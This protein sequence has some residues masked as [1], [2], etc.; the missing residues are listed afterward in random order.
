[1]IKNLFKIRD[2]YNGPITIEILDDDAIK[3]KHNIKKIPAIIID[4]VLVSEGEFLG[5]SELKKYLDYAN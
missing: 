3:K 2:I 4:G 5:T 1:M